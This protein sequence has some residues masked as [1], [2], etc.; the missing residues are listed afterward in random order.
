MS[1]MEAKSCDSS[2]TISIQSLVVKSDV[3]KEKLTAVVPVAA[4]DSDA[5]R[6]VSVRLEKSPAGLE[7]ADPAACGD[8]KRSSKP[9]RSDDSTD[10]GSTCGGDLDFWESATTCWEA[11][12][13]NIHHDA[14]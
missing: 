6:L 1:V 2:L 11:L 13:L 12:S 4:M 9:D 3:L 5:A 7:A 10:G 14:S 8:T